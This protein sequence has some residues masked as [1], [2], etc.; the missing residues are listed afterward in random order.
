MTTAKVIQVNGVRPGLIE[1]GM[2]H[3]VS[4]EN[5]AENLVETIPLRR[6]ETPDEVAQ[7]V[8]WLLSDAAAYVT[9][10]TITVSGGR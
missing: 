4:G 7:A 2:Q 5:R 10:S 9:G 6:V 8:L 3:H 1:T